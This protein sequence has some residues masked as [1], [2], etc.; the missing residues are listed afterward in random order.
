[1]LLPLPTRRSSDLKNKH[2]LKTAP[3]FST[4]RSCSLFEIYCY[5]LSFFS[6][7]ETKLYSTAVKIIV[8]YTAPIELPISSVSRATRKNTT[9]IAQTAIALILTP[10]K[11]QYF[12]RAFSNSFT[13]YFRLRTKK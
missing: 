11:Y 12:P 7:I 6:R 3:S 10:L 9:P 4:Y 5:Q 2:I 13:S 1:A 8:G